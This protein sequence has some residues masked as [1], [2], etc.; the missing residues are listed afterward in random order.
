MRIV[1]SRTVLSVLLLKLCLAF[2]VGQAQGVKVAPPVGPTQVPSF[3]GF[4]PDRIVVK[5]D[6]S[7]LTRMNR[8]TTQQGRTGIPELDRLAERFQVRSIV[9]QFPGAP[10]KRHGKRIIDLS[11]W[12]IVNLAQTAVF[13]KVSLPVPHGLSEHFL[14]LLSNVVP[15]HDRRR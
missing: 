10:P 15:A 9:Q 11:G 14:H 8:P 7:V 4:T 3:V 1:H 6:P 2:S 13:S 12:H 5:F